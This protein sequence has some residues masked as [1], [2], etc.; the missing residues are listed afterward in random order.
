M[1]QALTFISAKP[2]RRSAAEAGLV[3]KG[4][5]AM[6]IG[7]VG[8]GAVG[9]T[10]AYTMLV[11]GI[12][13]ELVLVDHNPALAQAHCQDMLHATPFT[14][15][16]HLRAGGFE[17]LE[18]A[19]IV[20]IAAGVPQ[21]PGETRTQL[22]GR[23]VAVFAEIVPRIMEYAP[24]TI[25]LVATNPLDVMTQVTS[26]LSGLAAGRVIGTGTMLDTARFQ[27]LLAS[28]LNISP[29]SVHAYVLGEHGDS[30]VLVWSSASVAG[31]PL[32][33]Y[34]ALSCYRLDAAE[35]KRID[36]G[37][38]RAAYQIIAGK[39]ATYYGIGAAVASLAR[40]IVQDER[41]VLTA[42]SLVPA[43]AGVSHVAL[44]LPVVVGREGIRQRFEPALDDAERE[45]LHAS[46][47]IIKHN[48]EQAMAALDMQQREV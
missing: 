19:A 27:S 43:I 44:S 30:E 2:R 24:S 12:A 47:T 14:H 3:I 26:R 41:R 4:D 28:R 31:L 10:A 42:C 11:Q 46:A 7:I 15:P 45:A 39:G 36:E 16:V 8:T 18:D 20:V 6:K 9:S 21:T 29:R 38:R 25:L 1:H 23:N 35:K 48:V 13:S 17:L 34:A 40:C 33:E 37:V 22:L 5:V 32:L